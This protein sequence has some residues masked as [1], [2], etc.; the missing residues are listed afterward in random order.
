MAL[1]SI[2]LFAPLVARQDPLITHTAIKLQPPSPQHWFGTDDLGR[3]VYSRVVYGSRVSLGIGFLGMLLSIVV[4]VAIA[5]VSGYFGGK[6]DMVIQRLVDAVQAIPG[7][8]LIL[9][10][11]D[12]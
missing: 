2:A 6:T 10:R 9:G 3:D 1:L 5:V 8:L 4:G 12:R 11:D 7:L